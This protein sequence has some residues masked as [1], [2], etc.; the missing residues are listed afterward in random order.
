VSPCEDETVSDIIRGTYDYHGENHG[1]PVF[2]RESGSDG[3]DVLL[4]YWDESDGPS[5][6][7]WWFGPKV[8][9]DQVWAYHV[10]S[11]ATLP[12]ERD[13]MIPY[14]GTIDP[15]FT[16]TK[17]TVGSA[18]HA[19]K[20]AYAAASGGGSKARRAA[21]ASG[22][23]SYSPTRPQSG[24]ASRHNGDLEE[25]P[26]PEE[27]ANSYCSERP[28]A[29]QRGVPLSAAPPP[30]A[31][32][33]SMGSSASRSLRPRSHEKRRRRGGGGRREEEEEERRRLGDKEE[34]RR[35]REEEN[36]RARAEEDEMRRLRDEEEKRRLM[37]EEDERRR[38]RDEEEKRRLMEE[39]DERRRLRDEEEKRRLM[40]EEE[41]K[42]RLRDEEEKRRLMEEE[43]EKRRVAREE[44]EERQRARDEE[45][46]KRAQAEVERRRLREELRAEERRREE[47][48]DRRRF[49]E[50]RRQEDERRRRRGEEDD[51]RRRD[52]DRRRR[53]ADR[54]RREQ[55]E[56]E[57]QR[58]EDDRR[59]RE[60][61]ARRIEEKKRRAAADERKRREEETS[62]RR[63]RKSKWD[64]E[65]PPEDA[66]KK[67]ISELVKEAERL[68]A[69][70]DAKRMEEEQ[71]KEE[72]RACV[73]VR[74]IIQRMH[75]CKSEEFEALKQELEETF[76]V[77][78]K[79]MGPQL[80]QK[81]E[82]EAVKVLENTTKRVGVIRATRKA[83]EEKEHQRWED[84]VRNQ[85]EEEEKK[86][87]D[88]A[89]KSEAEKNAARMLAELGGLVDAAEAK[90]KLLQESVGSLAK[91]TVVIQDLAPL[92]AKI[93]EYAEEAKF[94]H[95][96]CT[97]FIRSNSLNTVQQEQSALI[98]IR[99][100]IVKL[101]ARIN[102]SARS[103]QQAVQA[104][105]DERV[106]AI[107]KL[108]SKRSLELRAALFGKH[109]A[110]GDGAWNRAEVRSFAENEYGFTLDDEHLDRIFRTMVPDDEG[111]VLQKQFVQMNCLVGIFRSEK[112]TERRR[113]WE[114]VLAEREQEEKRR[115]E[116]TV[117]EQRREVEIKLDLLNQGAA[118]VESDVK[119]AEESVRALFSK[120]GTDIGPDE[121]A[122][123][124]GQVN[125]FTNAVTDQIKELR[126][127]T[128][129]FSAEEQLEELQDAVRK[130][131]VGFTHRLAHYENRT[132]RVLSSSSVQR[133]AVARRATLE[134]EKSRVLIV[135]S[136]TRHMQDA[137]LA[138]GEELFAG[139]GVEI[140]G[141]LSKSEFIEFVQKCDGDLAVGKLE[142]FFDSVDDRGEGYIPKEDF[143]KLLRSY[144]KVVNQTVLTEGLNIKETQTIRRC[145]IDEV[146]E[147]LEGPVVEQN[148]GLERVRCRTLRDGKEGWITVAGNH[149]TKYLEDGGNLYKVVKA[150]PLTRD[151]EPPPRRTA[152]SSLCVVRQLKVGELV[153]VLEWE[154]QDE[155]SS[156][157]RIKCKLKD[158]GDTGWATTVDEEGTV[159]LRIE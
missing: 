147:V 36:N 3:L 73:V 144:S 60:E 83:E 68:K 79:A 137:G 148:T 128:E 94:A 107:R 157:M 58:R 35:A 114:K 63:V 96:A 52:E 159:F 97:D 99:N 41:E 153:E 158:T 132:Q 140:D 23:R 90:T 100:Q 30:A 55:D 150:T 13:W 18:R 78:R 121:M 39:E 118:L 67:R 129:A 21:I 81:I 120:Q 126:E 133:D 156:A 101:L 69:E 20:G 17:G 85:L 59:R 87:Q 10:D 112:E 91:D 151:F 82:E 103:A 12:P 7:G 84:N 89:K 155:F 16:V 139:L 65:A 136:V 33:A 11:T 154:K 47:E 62:T 57:R 50:R 53:S 64:E 113:N 127:Q 24:S 26:E 31:A 2:K 138:N 92:V 98:L 131:I 15:T 48:E 51:R 8:G 134:Y 135:R 106:V 44:E 80:Q 40:E 130:K 28:G 88:E 19:K 141:L 29:R 56:K 86:Q 46:R 143:L 22:K 66:Q 37:E 72:T 76:A 109:D 77:E 1:R 43:E 117:A 71:Q 93:N 38:L 95:R 124:I 111:G 70:G 123:V 61:E 45:E 75:A 32:D 119:S 49:E 122:I 34:K 142:K 149:G 4:Y 152:K 14:D 25:E 108:A 146:V 5:F 125:Q 6:C 9:G 102:G 27:E 74:R 104:S 115:H 110:D 116:E 54:R 42:R 105:D 145:E